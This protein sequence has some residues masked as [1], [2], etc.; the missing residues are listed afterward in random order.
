MKLCWRTQN[1]I[2]RKKKS[3][4]LICE[5]KLCFPIFSMAK[6]DNYNFMATQKKAD[7]ICSSKK[8]I[9]LSKYI[10]VPQQ[11]I[12]K[13]LSWIKYSMETVNENSWLVYLQSCEISA[14]NLSSLPMLATYQ[15][16]GN[17]VL[18]SINNGNQMFNYLTLKQIYLTDK[19]RVSYMVDIQ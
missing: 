19:N 15:K 1:S 18:S 17:V 13:S 14:Q 16:S 4:S 11:S 6:I 2:Y 3:Q 8:S 10:I 7:G 5:L 9:T 12:D